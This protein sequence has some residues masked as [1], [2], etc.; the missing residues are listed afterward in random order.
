MSLIFGVSVGVG[1]LLFCRGTTRRQISNAINQPEFLMK[2]GVKSEQ[3]RVFL[4]DSHK[5]FVSREKTV[6]LAR[7]R[8]TSC[9]RGPPSCRVVRVPRPDA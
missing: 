3:K 2:S 8:R 1:V 6:E 4:V 7:Q 9:R 5:T